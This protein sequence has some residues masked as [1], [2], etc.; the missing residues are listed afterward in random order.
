MSTTEEITAGLRE[1]TRKSAKNKLS[2]DYVFQSGLQ[3]VICSVWRSQRPRAL[4]FGS[5]AARLPEL[6]V[7]NLPGVRMPVSCECCVLS[8]RGLCVGLITRP[9]EGYRVWCIK[10]SVIVKARY[11]EVLGH[12]GLPFPE[13]EISLNIFLT[14]SFQSMCQKSTSN[15]KIQ[16]EQ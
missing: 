12:K 8:V 14:G 16:I 3:A 11:E 7:R 13:K 4:R 10:M 6:R 9:E 2:L 15:C 5:E 1:E